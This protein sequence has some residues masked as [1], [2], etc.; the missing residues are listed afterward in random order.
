MIHRINMLLFLISVLHLV[1]SQTVAAQL[2]SIAN[3]DRSTIK[4]AASNIIRTVDT[5]PSRSILVV[6][7]KD[8]KDF[9]GW[10]A[11]ELENR[12]IDHVFLAL[13]SKTDSNFAAFQT[14]ISTVAHRW[15]LIFLIGKQD[16]PFLFNTL[17]RI[18]LSSDMKPTEFLFC[19]WLMKTETVIRT[20][21]IDMQ[22]L[23]A[24]RRELVKKIRQARTLRITSAVGTD[25]TLTPRFWKESEGEICTAPL[26]HRS[27]GTLVIDGCA[28]SGPPKEQFQ[29]RIQNGRVVNVSSLDTAD[30]QQSLVRFDL[31]RDENS[32]VLAEL[33]IGINPGANWAEELM[34]SEQARGTCHFG[35]GRNVQLKGGRNKSS[36][37]FDLVI[38]KPTIEVDGKRVCIEG[39][40][41]FQPLPEGAH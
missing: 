5:A 41:G 18:D 10:I 13:D 34:E 6:A 12:K 31:L 26:E 9:A 24:F 7:S 11:E 19:N 16:A 35:F 15:G 1:F 3:F 28:Y 37:H 36:Y 29:L 22:E 23:N 40:Y 20:Y 14:L 30:R 17:G 2:S 25:I 21:G 32:A 4:L 8:R 33:G 39:T 38:R 27:N